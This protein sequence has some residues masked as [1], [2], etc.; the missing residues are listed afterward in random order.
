[1]ET[2]NR[3]IEGKLE[4]AGKNV[5]RKMIENNNI[6]MTIRNPETYFRDAENVGYGL[7]KLVNMSFDVMLENEYI[8]IGTNDV[9]TALELH[10]IN[11]FFE[12][13]NYQFVALFSVKGKLKLTYVLENEKENKTKKVE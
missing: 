6:K 4:T 1:M 8:F 7:E 3:N 12:K 9:I 5:E 2:Q 11:E 10:E 13:H